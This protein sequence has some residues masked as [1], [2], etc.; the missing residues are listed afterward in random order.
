MRDELFEKMGTRK[1]DKILFTKNLPA[2]SKS[3]LH[4]FYMVRLAQQG[5]F[6]LISGA[7]PSLEPQAV[8][9]V[10]DTLISNS[11]RE[12]R[13]PNSPHDR[14]FYTETVW[15]IYTGLIDEKDE[16]VGKGY[17][18][19]YKDIMNA[20][21]ALIDESISQPVSNKSVKTVNTP[22]PPVWFVMPY[23][24]MMD[25]Q[26]L[27]FPGS[28]S[29]ILPLPPHMNTSN[30]S[31]KRNSSRSKGEES[32]RRSGRKE[33][34]KSEGNRDKSDRNTSSKSTVEDKNEEEES[35]DEMKSV[36]DEEAKDE[37]ESVSDEEDR[38]ADPDLSDDEDSEEEEE[39]EEEENEPEETKEAVESNKEK[40]A[41][42]V[43]TAEDE[44]EHKDTASMDEAEVAKANTSWLNFAASSTPPD[45]PS[46]HS[47]PRRSSQT[48]QRTKKY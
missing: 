25:S 8:Q 2:E 41:L 29:P 15:E 39:E 48:Y 45:S 12:S 27:T 4:F 35:K 22:Q 7:H 19:T 37:I 44:E 34:G 20:A 21:H 30:S 47:S 6:H 32:S 23:V 43:I 5:F 11:I 14:A 13:S 28:A 46:A 38:F 1:V 17:R 33:E 36:S 10:C 24:S 26:M 31:Q 42:T 18:T 40:E 9:Y 3:L 16:P